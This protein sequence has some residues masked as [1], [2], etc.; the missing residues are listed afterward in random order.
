MTIAH[1]YFN[2]VIADLSLIRI[3]YDHVLEYFGEAFDLRAKDRYDVALLN[4]LHQASWELD[5]SLLLGIQDDLIGYKAIHKSLLSQ[6]SLGVNDCH[7]NI[8]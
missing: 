5:H 1:L 2:I 7:F 4:L 8:Y 3:N 6:C